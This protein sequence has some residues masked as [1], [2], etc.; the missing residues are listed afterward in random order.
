MKK[1]DP[2][3]AGSTAAG[4]SLAFLA[5]WLVL[6]AYTALV[7]YTTVHHEP[8]R[9]EAQAWLIARDLP[10]TG[11]ISQMGY[12][13]SPALWQ[14]LLFPYA[15]FGAPYGSEAV[16]HVVLAVAGVGLLL[17]RGPFPLW[18][19]GL[20][21]FSALLSYEYAVVARNYNLTLL[22]LFA[23]AS[24][25]RSRMQRPV[26][27]GLLV[28]LLA[29]TNVHSVAMAAGLA[30]LYAFEARRL[31][32]RGVSLLGGLAI[33]ALG[34][35]AAL[36][37][38]GLTGRNAS[39]GVGLDPN[40]PVAV[41]AT[42]DAWLSGFPDLAALLVLAAMATVALA[43]WRLARPALWLLVCGLSGL[44]AIL[45]FVHSG[46][47][48]HRGLILVITVFALWVAWEQLS[49]PAGRKWRRAILVSLGVM[50]AAGL[51]FS[52]R[53]HLAD[54]R[55]LFSGARD[56][57]TYITESG[58]ADRVIVAYPSPH[59]SAVLPYLPGRQF[60]YADIQEPGTFV[61]WN[62]RYADNR[63]IGVAEAARRAGGAPGWGPGALLLLNEPLP[64]PEVY[65]LALRH[66]VVD[67]VFE[68]AGERMYL[69]ERTP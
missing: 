53:T 27:H 23:V 24:L 46:S 5:P 34:L 15:Q 12:E 26:L 65:G 11:I 13:G 62:R 19:K 22:L 67:G 57:A 6:L 29:N 68:A 50:L 58:L 42:R 16:I 64:A 18:F 43:L 32:R 60:W 17:V 33:M 28:A 4:R 14:L 31:G 2:A 37:Q 56:M 9:D 10:L 51:P 55:G 61:T 44:Y 49:L 52:V 63:A 69:Y 47:L 7:V 3:A 66:R 48:R 41:S 35:G 21:A 38:L 54:A 40:L 8:W 59:A 1:N 45:V 25:Y 30:L 36:A 39:V 20:L